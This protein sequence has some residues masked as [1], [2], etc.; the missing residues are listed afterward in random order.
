M[1]V[2]VGVVRSITSSTI[3]DLKDSREEF[4]NVFLSVNN[5]DFG[6]GSL[7]FYSDQYDSIV[8]VFFVHDLL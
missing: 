6:E 1:T 7:Y 3:T 4:K 8:F 2:Q 5:V